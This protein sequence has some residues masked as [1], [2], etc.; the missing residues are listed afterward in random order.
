MELPPQSADK[1]FTPAGYCMYCLMS[2]E[3]RQPGRRD[4]RHTSN[5]VPY[6]QCEQAKNQKD[7][8]K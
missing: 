7:A 1:E 3:A 6:G 2:L 8:G 4:V 5:E